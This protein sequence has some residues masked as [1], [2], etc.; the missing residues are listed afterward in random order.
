MLL[1]TVLPLTLI[2]FFMG[3]L[4]T[5]V[6]DAMEI[7]LHL[8]VLLLYWKGKRRKDL[9]GNNRACRRRTF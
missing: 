5:M 6:E 8:P 9:Y 3:Y 2:L 7:S 1:Y 4:V